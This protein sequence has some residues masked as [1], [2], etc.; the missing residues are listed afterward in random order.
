M[1]SP[2]PSRAAS[3]AADRLLDPAALAR[4]Q[5]RV[6]SQ[7]GAPWLHTEVARR[8]AERLPLIRLQPACVLDWYAGLG[9]GRSWLQQAYPQARVVAV[10]PAVAQR[11]ATLQ[12]L[13]S[14][15]RGGWWPLRRRPAE[16]A[17]LLA[18]EVPAD[19]AQLLWANM[20]LHGSRD[21]LATMGRWHQATAFD[22]CVMFSTLGPGTLDGLRALYARHGWP[23][24]HAPFVDMHDLGDMLV[25]AGFSDP[26]MDQETLTLHWADADAL[27]AELRGLGG[28]LH[29]QRH[30][31][32]RTPR[33][34]HRLQQALGELALQ[35]GRPALRFELVYGHAFKPQPRARMAAVTRLSADTLRMMARTRP[36]GPPRG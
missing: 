14:A 4:V 33:W 27:L 35:D 11:D 17:V 12:A 16:P 36:G 7:P 19:Q 10:E 34:R 8:M 26:V 30:A 32:L 9:G 2:E 1:P 20:V 24:P 28:N 6:L 22:G 21:P 5:Q 15:G 31:G 13:K 18:D 23:P 25:E 3:A 29:P